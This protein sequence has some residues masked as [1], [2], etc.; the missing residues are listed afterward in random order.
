NIPLWHR[1]GWRR[2]AGAVAVAWVLS[3]MSDA[4]HVRSMVLAQDSSAP[5]ATPAAAAT[6]SSA[7]ST[8]TA[9]VKPATTTETT[10]KSAEAN[11]TVSETGSS[12]PERHSASPAK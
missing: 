6:V 12:T 5:D 11:S 1:Q 7:S 2:A 3:G 8:P 9:S 10:A 4:R